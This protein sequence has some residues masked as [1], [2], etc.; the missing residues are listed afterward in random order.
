[1]HHLLHNMTLLAQSSRLEHLSRGFRSNRVRLDSNDV[2]VGL[3]IL[4]VLILLVWSATVLYGWV[5]QLRRKPGPVRLFYRLCRAHGLAVR[6]VVLLWK[7]ARQQRLRD[8]A[9][10]FLEPERYEPAHLGAALREHAERFAALRDRLFETDEVSYPGDG[11][12]PAWELP[13]E[14]RESTPVAPVTE[15]PALPVDAMPELPVSGLGGAG[16]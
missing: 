7:L 8:P 11:Q 3:L 9:R 13:A 16:V 10:L 2:M 1:M 5:S 4:A 15:K 6:D 12:D 14:Q